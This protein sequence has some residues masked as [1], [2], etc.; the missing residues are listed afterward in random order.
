MS[1]MILHLDDFDE[2]ELLERTLEIESTEVDALLE[3]TEFA[4]SDGLAAEFVADKVGTTIR[5][6]GHVD[7]VVAYQ[8][9]RCLEQRSMPLD[10][11]PEFVLMERSDW[12]QEYEDEDEIA[13]EAD[14]MDVSVY[15]GEEIDLA[16]L[17]RE[18]IL[19]DL[20][21]HPRCPDTQREACD[22]AYRQNVGDEALE[23]LDEAAMDQRWA[24][25]K[26]IKL[27]D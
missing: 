11:D 9:G 22:E 10:I 27:K 23:E 5:V 6:R 20:P 7:G 25:L 4:S 12:S 15:E 21:T 1:G 19:L 14:D 16:P 3:G 26:D 2:G 8:C 17:V 13:L 24:P 18:A